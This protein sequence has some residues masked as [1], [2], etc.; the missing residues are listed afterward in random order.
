MKKLLIPLLT[1]LLIFVGTYSASAFS[2]YDE[3]DYGY[4]Y[5]DFLESQDI[6][7]GYP[8]GTFKPN[9]KIN[10]AE[11]LKI[12]L[13]AAQSDGVLEGEITGS[14][15]YY[16]VTDQWY[17]PYVCKADDLGYVEGY[18]DGNFR[19]D[20]EINFVEASK[21]IVNVMEL[22]VNDDY[23]ATWFE[24]YVVALENV[25]A[26]PYSI[27]SF[28]QNISRV[29]MA[30][31]IFDTMGGGTTSYSSDVTYADL[32]ILDQWD[33]VERIVNTAGAA[34]D[35]FK[36]EG[37]LWGIEYGDFYWI[38][39]ADPDSFKQLSKYFYVDDNR[40][41]SI[42]PFNM[43]NFSSIRKF[44]DV[45]VESLEYIPSLGG[46]YS[47]N[48]FIKDK[49]TVFYA[50]FLYLDEL[51]DVDL[52]TF[53][54][55]ACMN[56]T[57][58]IDK[59]TFY[60][61]SYGEVNYLDVDTESFE[62]VSDSGY[63]SRFAK[64]KNSVYY[65]ELW[66]AGGPYVFFDADPETFELVEWEYKMDFED[67]GI[68]YFVKDKDSVWVKVISKDEL[69]EFE[70]VDVASFEVGTDGAYLKVSDKDHSYEYYDDLDEFKIVD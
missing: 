52:E 17:A 31:I 67:F 22:P 41:Y 9:N 55:I 48:F 53:E 26:I 2:D 62:F 34:G 50:N 10:R 19:P 11:F 45:D 69:F 14:N 21:I 28:S 33:D 57:C 42:E 12:A 27:L 70:E 65:L 15:C 59:D 66:L 68:D 46:E 36:H 18:S 16:D 5:V 30:E 64:D 40:V 7:S 56:E 13:N 60:S 23:N 39:G 25:N 49:N 6:L 44:D 8:D 35:F 3:D 20:Q 43:Y 38:D 4:I 47:N 29:D 32:K 58:G 1:S 61:Y 37:K 24:K 54:A 63:Y 51:V